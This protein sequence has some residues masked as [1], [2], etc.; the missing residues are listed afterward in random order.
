M[1]ARALRQFWDRR[2]AETGTKPFGA[3]QSEIDEHIESTL[4]HALDNA[5]SA[6]FLTSATA[7]LAFLTGLFTDMPA[8]QTCV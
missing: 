5:S 8:V 1:R 3:T 4:M 6:I 2:L 7:C